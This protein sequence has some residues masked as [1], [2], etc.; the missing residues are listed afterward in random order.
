[1]KRIIQ[2]IILGV[3]L[4]TPQIVLGQ[5]LN[6]NGIGHYNNFMLTPH[7]G[8]GKI[9][10]HTYVE[11][12]WNTGKVKEEKINDYFYYLSAIIF[13]KNSFVNDMAMY[14]SI[15]FVDGYRRI[16]IF[17]K[18]F[19]GFMDIGDFINKENIF[20]P[21]EIKYA[22]IKDYGYRQHYLENIYINRDMEG[23]YDFSPDS[24]IRY[25]CIPIHTPLTTNINKNNI[26]NSYLPINEKI[27][28]Y[29]RLF[30]ITARNTDLEKKIY[31]Y[32]YR[33]VKQKTNAGE[34]DSDWKDF[35]QGG[36]KA[37]NE[38]LS[39]IQLSASDIFGSEEEA[40]KHIG[41]KIQIR[42]ASFKYQGEYLSWSEPT[43][44]LTIT[45]SA[46]KLT[47]AAP[48]LRCS[49]E[50][51]TMTIGFSRKPYDGEKLNLFI[52]NSEN[53]NIKF[54]IEG[55]KDQDITDVLKNQTSTTPSLT[56]NNI[57]EGTYKIKLFGNYTYV[58][59]NGK[60]QSTSTYTS[61]PEHTYTINVEAPKP[62]TAKQENVTTK[63]VSCYNATDG[64]ISFSE[65]S[66]GTPPYSY[67][68]VETGKPIN[69]RNWKNFSQSNSFSEQGLPKG[70][71][72]IHIKDSNNCNVQQNGSTTVFSATISAP[73]AIQL[74]STPEQPNNYNKKGAVVLEV[75]GGTSPYNY[76]IR[77]ESAT[78]SI[79]ETGTIS[80]SSKHKVAIDKLS[81]GTYYVKVTDSK[82]CTSSGNF[83]SI[84]APL[85]ILN[86]SHTDNLCYGESKGTISFEVSGGTPPYYYKFS[87]EGNDKHTFNGNKTTITNL[88]QGGYNIFI[89]DKDDNPALDNGTETA[90]YKTI[91]SPQ[92]GIDFQSNISYL[93]S[94]NANDGVIEI[95][96]TGGTPNPSGE[97]EFEWRRQNATGN[98]ITSGI[99]TIVRNGFIIRLGN[100]SAGDYH[101]TV[102]DI[103]SCIKTA[104]FSVQNPLS[105]I[106]FLHTNIKCYGSNNGGFSLQADGGKL[107]YSYRLR[108][109]ETSDEPWSTFNGKQFSRNDLSNGSYIFEL[110]DAEGNTAITSGQVD[111]RRFTVTQPQS[112]LKVLETIN[113]VTGNGRTDGRI[114]LEIN[115]G[116]PSTSGY[117]VLLENKRGEAI[118]ASTSNFSA[119]IHRL[120]FTHLAAGDYQ[121]R[122][123][124]ANYSQSA[125][126]G[127][128]AEKK[129][130]ITTPDALIAQIII[131]KGISCHQKTNHNTSDNNNNNLI[132]SNEDGILKVEVQG[133]VPPYNYHWYRVEGSNR[134][135]IG[136]TNKISGLRTG[137]YLVEVTDK[138]ENKTSVETI[139]SEPSLLQW[140]M[141]SDSSGCVGSAEGKAWVRVQGGTPPYKY[142]WN[143]G[144]TTPEL[145]KLSSGS[146]VVVVTDANGC[147]FTDS[148]VVGNASAIEIEEE[149]LTPP[150]C[151][152]LSDGSI[153]FTIRGGSGN[154]SVLWDNGTTTLTR[155]GLSSGSYSVTITDGTP[156]GFLTKT[157]TLTAPDAITLQLPT[158]LTICQGDNHEF[159]ISIS[160]T[161]ARYEWLR[162]GEIFSNESKVNIV[163]E[164][165]YI[166]KVVNSKGC[167]GKSTIQVRLSN[168]RLEVNFLVTSYAFYDY[169]VR[170]VNV[171][172]RLDTWQ[173]QIPPEAEIISQSADYVDVKFPEAGAYTVG[174]QGT[175]GDCQKVMYKTLLVEKDTFGEGLEDNKASNI[176]RFLVSPNPNS[177]TFRVL[178]NLH[179]TEN[180]RLRIYDLQGRQ[181]L[182]VQE[183]SS[184]IDF[185]ILYNHNF[186]AGQYLVLLE[187][188]REIRIE[189]MIV[190]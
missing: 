55:S 63:P 10:D 25:I 174:L 60:T 140:Q 168:Q 45:P 110:R 57:T 183:K 166:A 150:S 82:G 115:G 49:Y 41:K 179:N 92:K 53:N 94:Y 30:S 170:L 77:S 27:D 24:G 66:G 132:D 184:G 74:I 171:G 136:I 15:E 128:L 113:G 120:E 48:K 185:E 90:L 118:T 44:P 34:T 98:V 84:K 119:G 161:Q 28:I 23:Q 38:F 162:N 106:N 112:A 107:P 177:G 137:K 85:G 175:L 50:K 173:W 138:N 20:N 68:V 29:G 125:E 32:Q 52:E 96:V 158:E 9:Y 151:V 93:S 86:S 17:H 186:A 21:I 83:F 129:L 117:V 88:A 78:G 180:I 42:V 61:G 100:L 97:Y 141:G 56:I 154:Y 124:D 109:T 65:I 37:H 4:I 122:I 54:P 102:K 142:Q 59:A 31:N 39:V 72:Q 43:I 149:F 167:E 146:Y 111:I 87:K 73:E 130:K 163:E 127:C 51:G 76:E 71:Y 67:Q 126:I 165:E 89:F 131:E 8:I 123:V 64:S 189:K 169:A 147:Q 153:S 114:T 80:N 7:T 148:V 164:G 134:N 159:D 11:T 36:A 3:Y 181:I 152:G 91:S 121:L 133:G 103:N 157:F 12:Y 176:R 81:S 172:N 62:I 14:E 33:F 182:P 26:K 101:L 47:H 139:L 190:K 99:S 70:S 5:Y 35:K 40:K 178:V 155:K 1:M 188:G 6:M 46:P 79:V 69:D 156:C 19:T 16:P 22:T 135:S 18:A 144:G 143:N 160:D 187:A 116:T 58:D 145:T 104:T 95:I 108:K 2:T 13:L 105:I 75:L